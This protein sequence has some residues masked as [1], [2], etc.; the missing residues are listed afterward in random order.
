MSIVIKFDQGA[1]EQRGVDTKLNRLKMHTLSEKRV[2]STVPELVSLMQ[3]PPLAS[4]LE[5]KACLMIINPFF[6]SLTSL[7]L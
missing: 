1:T 3:I 2:K 5:Q 4:H 6:L 7:W